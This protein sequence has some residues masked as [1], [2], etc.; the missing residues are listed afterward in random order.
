MTLTQ[1]RVHYLGLKCI[2][3]VVVEVKGLNGPSSLGLNPMLHTA[4]LWRFLSAGAD[5]SICMV[6]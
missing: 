3:G 2:R 6:L 4:E 1:F 5:V